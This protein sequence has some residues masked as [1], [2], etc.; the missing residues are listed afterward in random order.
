MLGFWAALGVG[1]LLKGPVILLVAGAAIISL[2]IADRDFAGLKNLRPLAGI[3]L[4]LLIVLPW[5]V[6]ISG[7]GGDSNPQG[8]FL[9]DALLHDLL[10]KLI[11]G[12]ES[13]GAPPGS[14]LAAGLLTAW[15]WSLLA[16]FAVIA[17]WKHRAEP[18]VRF[19]LAW[20]IP[21]WIVFELVPT[22]MPHYTMPLYPALALLIAWLISREDF[23]QRVMGKAAL[24]WRIVWIVPALALGGGVV[25][26]VRQYGE[27]VDAGTAI[28]ALLTALTGLFAIFAL[29]DRL[30]MT[31]AEMTATM[32]VDE[33]NSWCAYMRIRERR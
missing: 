24:A 23:K 4:L 12:Q 13:H 2:C 21:A 32:T 14:Y 33:F 3:P 1:I 27:G 18:A 22:K 5:L 8:N 29:A 26:A 17:A 25:F 15:P 20:L 9:S 30:H 10:P 31:V 16:P 11:G 19:C 7:G 28:A 6:A